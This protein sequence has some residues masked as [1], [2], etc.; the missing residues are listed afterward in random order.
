M[1]ELRLDDVFLL[2]GGGIPDDGD[3][4]F[5]G[6]AGHEHSTAPV[7]HESIR[8]VDGSIAAALHN[9]LASLEGLARRRWQTASGGAPG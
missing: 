2:V 1:E 7:M 9:H 3:Q 5:E 8:D 6:D 4:L